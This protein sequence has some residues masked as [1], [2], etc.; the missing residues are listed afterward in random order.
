MSNEEDM[1]EISEVEDVNKVEE[2]HFPTQNND[3]D[4]TGGLRDKENEVNYH[5]PDIGKKTDPWQPVPPV[6]KTVE[7]EEKK[8]PLDGAAPIAKNVYVMHPIYLP[9]SEK[10]KKLPVPLLFIPKRLSRINGTSHW[11]LTKEDIESEEMKT[12]VQKYMFSV[13]QGLVGSYFDE[14]MFEREVD[15]P[16]SEWVQELVED[17]IILG[18]KPAKE[19]A[20]R[21]NAVKLRGNAAR[22]RIAALTGSGR[23]GHTTLFGTGLEVQL[24]PRNEVDFLALDMAVSAD[25]AKAGYDTQGLFFQCSQ[26][27]LVK[28]LWD[29]IA[30]SII[31]INLKE[32][33]EDDIDLAEVIRINDLISLY[34]GIGCVNF[35]FGYPVDLPCSTGPLDC[36]HIE[37]LKL[38]VAKTLW[39]NKGALTKGQRKHLAKPRHFY[40]LKDLDEYQ[41]MSSSRFTDKIEVEIAEK[42]VTL[43]LRVPTIAEYLDAGQRWIS[44]LESSL[45]S[46]IGEEDNEYKVKKVTE[47]AM[48]LTFLRNYAH[49]VN[50][51]RIGDK[52]IIDG[53]EDIYNAL[54]ELSSINTDE[55]V[56]TKL[57]QGLQSFTEKTQI[58]LVAIPNYSCPVCGKDHQSPE[59]VDNKHPE[60]VPL[61]AMKL[62]FGLKDRLLLRAGHSVTG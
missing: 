12:F 10:D 60:L 33:K 23:V 58:A 38:N 54:D 18:Y 2:E 51:I 30:G 62:F 61:D 16:S 46:V 28:H 57:T 34:H 37:R 21:E 6:S 43:K 15:N 53:A 41:E 35:P 22:A 29:F 32:H 36:T 47:D 8:H 56:I 48:R 26:Y 4:Y 7:D 1:K 20:E 31:N 44:G 39:I 9:L 55:D 19:A 11:G 40:S 49:L 25:K 45:M 3:V 24:K 17:D 5:D 42:K 50:E 14:G 59:D 13:G 27:G 52:E